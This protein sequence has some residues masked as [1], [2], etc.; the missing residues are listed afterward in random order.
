MKCHTESD[1]LTSGCSSHVRAI[2]ETGGKAGVRLQYVFYMLIITISFY[3]VAYSMTNTM[4]K[5]YHATIL[6]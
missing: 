5:E 6:P 2:Q 3:M 4:L 1:G